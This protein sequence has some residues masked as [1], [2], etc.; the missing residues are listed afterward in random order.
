MRRALACAVLLLFSIQV[1]A[2]G[3]PPRGEW[4]TLREQLA[5]DKVEP[6]SA[7]ER[8]ILEN[9]EFH[10]LRAEEAGDHLPLPP[11]L[12]VWWRKGHPEAVYSAKDP[13]GGYP[14]VLKEIHEWL[15]SHQDLEPGAPEPAVAPGRVAGVTGELRISGLQPN[16]RSESDIRINFWD[17][18]RI[19]SASNN[20]SGSGLQAQYYS[21]DGGATWGQ[22]VLPRLPGVLS[23]PLLN[24]EPA[25]AAG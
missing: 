8:L 7:L 10:L 5:R 13:T 1:P 21:F 14:F 24:F 2:A 15:R 3:D 11:W 20:L 19:I 25:A 18:S 6:G 16:P 22:T 23:R 4:P 12:R 17:P 9:Q